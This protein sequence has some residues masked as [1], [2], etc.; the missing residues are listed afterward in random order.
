MQF[1]LAAAFVDRVSGERMRGLAQIAVEENLLL[2]AGWQY[3]PRDE[4]RSWD[5]WGIFQE[6]KLSESRFECYAALA[7]GNLHGLMAL[8]LG[9]KRARPTKRVTVDYLATNPANRTA[10]RGLGH[11]GVALIA[12]ALARSIMCGAGGRVWLEG[13]PG[14]IPF[15]ERLGL[16]KQPGPTPDGNLVYTPQLVAAEQL[17]DEIRRQGI[18][19]I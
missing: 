13:L 5:W 8:D 10:G 3:R 14:A 18:L 15:Y 19:E 4:D 6:C 11:V 1:P 7:Q 2:W 9:A 16:V 17:L 12:V